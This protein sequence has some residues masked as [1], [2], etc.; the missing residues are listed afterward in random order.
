MTT[1]RFK[2]LDIEVYE[3]GKSVPY[4]FFVFLLMWL[5]PKEPIHPPITFAQITKYL[6]VSMDLFGPT[7]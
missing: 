1:V 5:G 2:K 4:T 6:F 3:P 7:A